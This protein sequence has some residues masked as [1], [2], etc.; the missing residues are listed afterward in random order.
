[1]TE[2]KALSTYKSS[3]KTWTDESLSQWQDFLAMMPQSKIADDIFDIVNG[4]IQKRKERR[5]RMR[6]LRYPGI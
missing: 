4:E 6:V 3:V 1:M 5:E 2:K